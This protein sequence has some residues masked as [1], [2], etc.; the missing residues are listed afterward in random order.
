M[1]PGSLPARATEIYQEGMRIPPLKFY[2]QGVV[3]KTLIELLK[4]NNRIPDIFMGD[5]NAQVSAVKIGAR[6]LVELADL[7]GFNQL[8]AIFEDLLSR[9]EILTREALRVVPEGTYHCVDWLD[10]DGIDLDKRIRVEVA[11]TVKNG[12]LTVTFPDA[13]PQVRGPAN[14]STSGAQA[15][16][17]FVVRVIGGPTLPTNGGCFRPV[18]VEPPLGSLFNPLEPAPVNARSWTVQHIASCILGALSEVV[19]MRICAGS[20]GPS[21]V[22]IFANR[23]ANGKSNITGDF[24]VGGSGAS[25]NCDGVDGI[26]TETTNGMNVPSEALEL[27]API[28]INRFELRPDSGGMGEFRG[29]LGTTREYE[30]LADEMVFTH[31]GG[32]HY[33]PAQ[34]ARGGQAGAPAQSVIV[35]ADGTEEEVPSKLTTE[36]RY[37]DRVVV[38]TPGG[39]GYGDSRRRGAEELAFDL[40]SGKVTCS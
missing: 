16:A 38:Q 2:D 25:H 21:S 13:T 33:A 26:E 15:A 12:T 35:R 3:N 40:K 17:Y 8:L 39:G 20:S 7:Y 10:N 24:V 37:G 23:D 27:L 28:R 14:C 29:G 11:V 6:R 30:C 4:I 9:S 32:R 1:T 34:G 18:S 36:L 22:L 5:L 31:R 19:P